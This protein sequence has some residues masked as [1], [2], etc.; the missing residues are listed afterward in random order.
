M[1]SKYLQSGFIAEAL[2]VMDLRLRGEAVLCCQLFL[3]YANVRHQKNTR[4]HSPTYWWSRGDLMCYRFVNK[5]MITKQ[6][7]HINLIH[8]LYEP[9]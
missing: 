1:S 2:V 9:K 7:A 6:R 3:V 5:C 4:V 8:F